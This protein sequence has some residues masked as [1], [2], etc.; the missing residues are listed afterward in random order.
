[1]PAVEHLVG[2]AER[3]SERPFF[4][5]EKLCVKARNRNAGCARCAEAC[6]LGCLVVDGGAPELDVLACAGCGACAAA[7]P[8]GALDVGAPGDDE[9]LEASFPACSATGGDVVFAC[10]DLLDRVSGMVDPSK[11]V[12]VPCLACLT[13]ELVVEAV[14]ISGAQRVS[15]SHGFCEECELGSGRE[16]AKRTVECARELLEAW[17]ETARV[18]TAGTLPSKVR[19]IGDEDHDPCRRRFFKD[20]RDSVKSVA[21]ASI[22]QAL[23]ASFGQAEEPS[24]RAHVD[25]FG[26]LPRGRSL[27]RERLISALGS[28]GASHVPVYEKGVAQTVGEGLWARVAI[29]AGVCNGCRMCA[30]FC[31][32][33][34]LYPFHTKK[35]LVG[36]KQDVALCI[37]C[38]CCEDICPT[39][40]LALLPGAAPE[41]VS[42]RTVRR[43]VLPKSPLSRARD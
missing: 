17:G 1:M 20:V 35:G 33:G 42:G 15:L 7:C 28:L 16:S 18:R 4:V 39:N 12:S 38:G 43:F 25:R 14:I 3:L 5:D 30:T 27:R 31:P 36:V 9:L 32:T 22:D 24:L 6:P 34:A 8:S 13:P 26:M 2:L 40:A 11:I 29:D 23:E 10:R 21:D 37:A 19:L 41:D